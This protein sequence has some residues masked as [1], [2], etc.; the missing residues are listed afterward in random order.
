MP[1]KNY[2][3]FINEEVVVA[4]DKETIKNITNNIIGISNSVKKSMKERMVKLI[5][6]TIDGQSVVVNQSYYVAFKYVGDWDV[7]DHN[8]ESYKDKRI[9][10]KIKITST[11]P[12]QDKTKDYPKFTYKFGVVATQILGKTSNKVSKLYPKYEKDFEKSG[13]G[14]I[15]TQLIFDFKDI[16]KLFSDEEKKNWLKEEL[17]FKKDEKFPI[18]DFVKGNEPR[19]NVKQAQVSSETAQVQVSGETA[20]VQVPS[21]TAQVQG[22]E[23]VKSKE[24]QLDV[25]KNP[26]QK[27]DVKK[28]QAQISK[29]EQL[30]KDQEQANKTLENPK[31]LDKYD[32][33]KQAQIKK[34]HTQ[35]QVK[36]ELKKQKETQTTEKEVQQGTKQPIVKK[37]GKKGKTTTVQGIV[38]KTRYK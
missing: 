19:P 31:N 10:Y 33:K 30:K 4:K 25:E 5:G 12:T 7:T 28:A 24:V 16:L 18:R 36:K 32:A 8:N 11:D 35:V 13:E 27:A 17:N 23:D 22:K 38:K 29:E 15:G 26:V 21:E 34:T 20:Q 9:I 14:V 37:K 2:K 1:Y 6:T 3:N